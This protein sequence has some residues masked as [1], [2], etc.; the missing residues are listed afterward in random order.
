[1]ILIRDILKIRTVK[2]KRWKRVHCMNSKQKKVD[3]V[4]SISAQAD[5]EARSINKN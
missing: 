3:I 5:F 2:S 1:M 4:I